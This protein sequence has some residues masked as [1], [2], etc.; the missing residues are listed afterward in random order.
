V[1]IDLNNLALLLQATN[2]LA[3]AEPLMRKGLEILLQFYVKTG[4]LHP[5]LQAVLENYMLILQQLGWTKTEITQHLDALAKTY[6]LQFNGDMPV[7]HPL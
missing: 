6:D 1:A 3:E 7:S 5:Q 2:R 4:H